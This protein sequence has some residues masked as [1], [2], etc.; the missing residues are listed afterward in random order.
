MSTHLLINHDTISDLCDLYI[1]PR[2]SVKECTGSNW[3]QRWAT[4]RRRRR[5]CPT[6][7]SSYPPHFWVGRSSQRDLPSLGWTSPNRS[8][9]WDNKTLCSINTRTPNMSCSNYCIWQQ[10]LNVIKSQAFLRSGLKRLSQFMGSWKVV[11][12]K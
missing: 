4:H 1:N 9:G 3:W 10:F 12:K 8:T 7:F 11:K 6:L 5:W 2:R